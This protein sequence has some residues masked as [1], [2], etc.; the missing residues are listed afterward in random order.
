M[1]NNESPSEQ[2]YSSPLMKNI[3]LPRVIAICGMK[4][5]GKDTMANMISDMY[6]YQNIKISQSLKDMLSVAFGFTQNQMETD[7]KD[8]IDTKWGVSPRRIMQFMGTEV[9]QYELQKVIPDIGRTFWIRNL[10]E[11]H[12]APNPDKKYVI[13]DLRFVHEYEALKAYDIY[14]IHIDR[15]GGKQEDT[16]ASHHISEIEYKSIPFDMKYKNESSLEDMK[17]FLSKTFSYQRY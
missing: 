15:D 7:E 14:I 11:S 10:I 9:M 6:G 4:R 8:H 5:S 16:E 2:S 17:S 13:S 3:C 1:D 12:I